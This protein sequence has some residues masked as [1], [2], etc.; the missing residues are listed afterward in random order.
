[1]CWIT[2]TWRNAATINNGFFN[3]TMIPQVAQNAG[4]SSGLHPISGL[5]YLD[6]I[7]H[8]KARRAIQIFLFQLTKQSHKTKI[9]QLKKQSTTFHE[10]WVSYYSE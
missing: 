5:L 4:C 1:M 9:P 3:P 6:Q 8:K 10:D 7:T 2:Q